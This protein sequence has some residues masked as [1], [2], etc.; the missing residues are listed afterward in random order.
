ME[1]YRVDVGFPRSPK[2]AALAR[3][4]G[5]KRDAATVAVLRLLDFAAVACETGD[6]TAVHADDVAEAMGLRGG[7][8]VVDALVACGVLDRAG[9]RLTIHGWWERQGPLLAGRERTRRV[10]GS[11]NAAPADGSDKPAEASG[12][13]NPAVKRV[14]KAS[15]PAAAADGTAAE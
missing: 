4:L 15:A 13:A 8:R 6:L 12:E 1:W 3:E 11:G 2:V 7:Q 14:R 5:V 9:G 10:A